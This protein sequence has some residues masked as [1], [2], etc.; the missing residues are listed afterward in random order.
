[1]GGCRRFSV[2]GTNNLGKSGQEK[3][4]VCAPK[5]V[6]YSVFLIKYFQNCQKKGIGAGPH[7]HLP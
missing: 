3:A 4:Q 2:R 6:F 5:D 7:G 1:M